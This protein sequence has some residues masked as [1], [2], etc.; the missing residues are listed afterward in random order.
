MGIVELPDD[1]RPLPR[2]SQ[3]RPFF[4]KPLNQLFN[5]I[6]REGGIFF[7]AIFIGAFFSHYFIDHDGKWH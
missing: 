1:V 4:A 2:V 5:F 6:N 7:G 3:H